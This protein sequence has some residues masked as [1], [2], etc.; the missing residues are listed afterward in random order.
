MYD[1]E[2]N[3]EHS[4]CQGLEGDDLKSV[5]FSEKQSFI[6]I[7]N[8]DEYYQS[9]NVSNCDAS[10]YGR[11]INLED[12]QISYSHIMLDPKT[13]NYFEM[14]RLKLE[15][16]QTSKGAF[17]VLTD[18]DDPSMASFSN[19]VLSSNTK[20]AN[21]KKSLLSK[22]ECKDNEYESF[23]HSD[24]DPNNPLNPGEV[25]N[26]EPDYSCFDKNEGKL[27]F[28]ITRYNKTTQKEKLITKTRRI[29]SKCPHTSMKYYAKGM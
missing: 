29:I 15:G 27:I 25:T 2:I 21:S 26:F 20:Y 11:D 13:P 17:I 24:V 28:K 3:V 10:N 9:Y 8:K 18:L 1:G 7:Y 23:E 4:D 5:K 14:P 6:H 12:D 19:K 16:R 22:E